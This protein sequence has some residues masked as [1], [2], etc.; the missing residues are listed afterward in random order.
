MIRVYRT[1]GRREVARR[2]WY[3]LRAAWATLRTRPGRLRPALAATSDGLT[4]A[5]G[6]RSVDIVVCVHNALDDIQRCLASLEQHCTP[7]RRLLLVDDGSNPETANYLR[8]Y[9]EQH[10]FRLIRN[11]TARGYTFAANQG[12]RAS[13]ADQ[14]VLLNSDT[15]VTEGWLDAMLD[16]LHSDPQIGLVG[17]LSNTASWQSIPFIEEDGDWKTNEVPEDLSLSDYARALRLSMP[18]RSAEVGFINGFCLLI[19][20]STLHHVGLFDEDNFGKGY[21]EENDF[22]LRAHKKGWKLSICLQA[23][24]FHAQSKSYSNERR[25]KLCSEAD[26]RLDAKHGAQIKHQR[27]ACTMEHPMLVFGRHASLSCTELHQARQKLEQTHAGR[28]LLILLPAGHA[29][30]GSNVVIQEALALQAAGVEIWLANL[31]EHRTSFQASY[32]GLQL[33]CSYFQLSDPDELQ[34]Q[35]QGFDAVVA[36]HNLSA[37]WASQLQ[38]IR[39]GY[40]IQDYEPFFYPQGSQG[41]TQALQSYKLNAPFRTFCKTT[42]NRDILLQESQ[43]TSTVIGPSVDARSYAPPTIYNS[44]PDQPLRIA[45]MIR[46]SCERRQ[47]RRTA[48]ILQQLKRRF[49]AHVQIVAFGSS[50]AELMAHGIHPGSFTNLGRLTPQAVGETLQSAEIFIDAS[51]FQAMGLTAMEAMASGCAVI[52]P[53]RGGLAEI[54]DASGQSL[55]TCVDTHSTSAVVE[56]CASLITDNDLRRKRGQQGMQVSRFHPLLAATRMLDVIFSDS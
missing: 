49:G 13:S 18:H 27:L 42:W 24:V 4:P 30:G 39:L 36:T 16:T 53:Q 21:G 54:T 22:C 20:R 43:L 8:A 3:K 26:R 1:E 40:Y 50:D 41:Q 15:I 25:Q 17:P 5:P 37:H 11:E 23:Y 55:A 44:D 52:G 48:E 33:P 51:S 14:I 47:P 56:S 35:A 7:Q 6:H 9:A 29:G 34:F 12:L 32:P 45:A 31:P 38:D 2:S 28:R 10:K 19:R 46:V